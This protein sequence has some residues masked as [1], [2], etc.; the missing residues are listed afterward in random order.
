MQENTLVKYI[1]GLLEECNLP[2]NGNQPEDIQHI[3]KVDLKRSLLNVRT[4]LRDEVSGSKK[5]GISYLKGP[6]AMGLQPYL[7]FITNVQH[8]FYLTRY[9]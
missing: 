7:V 8:R 1:S 2:L 5:I 3:S 6:I 4:A 9:G